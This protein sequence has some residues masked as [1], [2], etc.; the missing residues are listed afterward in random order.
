[1]TQMK[2][3]INIDHVATLRNARGGIHPDPIQAAQLAMALGADFITAH[4][5]E[6]RRHIKDPDIALLKELNIPLNLEIALAEEMLNIAIYTQPMYVCIVP[7]KREELTTE[8]GLNVVKY[9][10][11]LEN[12]I[13]Q[14]KAQE[15]TVSLFIE[16]EQE[17]VKAARD[18]CADMVELHTGSYCN[19]KHHEQLFHFEKIEKMAHYAVS[20]G[21]K[22]AA[23]HGLNY[24]TTSQI[25]SIL[26]ISELNIGHFI[27]GESIFSGLNAVIQ[28]MKTII[29]TARNNI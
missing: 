2:L 26:P 27:I 24:E 13:K 23:G 3:G 12:F 17:Q 9:Y 20:L 15:I 11:Q 22:C 4:L 10:N 25:A 1:M 8:G 28:K 18:L 14:L 5:R 29:A 6:D 19:S 16:A 21:L 7:E